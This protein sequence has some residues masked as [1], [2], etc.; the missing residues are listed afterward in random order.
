[1]CS[2][3]DENQKG[4]DEFVKKENKILAFTAFYAEK[5]WQEKRF[6]KTWP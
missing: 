3:H 5:I 4:L 1:L 2:S 6:K